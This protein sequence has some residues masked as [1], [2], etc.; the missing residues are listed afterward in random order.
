MAIS[1]KLAPQSEESIPELTLNVGIGK[2]MIL[3]G[4]PIYSI[5]EGELHDLVELEFE[6]T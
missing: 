3:K 1:H 6:T 4:E 5:G 2:H